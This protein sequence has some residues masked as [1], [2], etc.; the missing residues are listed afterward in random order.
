MLDC[1]G[2]REAVESVAAEWL[3][4]SDRNSGGRLR[5]GEGGYFRVQVIERRKG[6]Q[7]LLPW[8]SAAGLLLICIFIYIY[9]II[10]EQW[11]LKK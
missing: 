11:D 3:Q 9:R 5:V 10:V 4:I 8:R 6:A 7:V 1:G 2:L